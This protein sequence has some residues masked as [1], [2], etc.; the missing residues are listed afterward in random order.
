MAYGVGIRYRNKKKE[1]EIAIHDRNHINDQK[2]E[3]DI[4]IRNK[5]KKWEYGVIKERNKK[6]E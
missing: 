1:L 4:G 2:Q 5:H 3:L 6:D